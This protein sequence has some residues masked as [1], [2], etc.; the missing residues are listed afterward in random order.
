MVVHDPAVEAGN[1]RSTLHLYGADIAR[2]AGAGE[3]AHLVAGLKTAL[4]RDGLLGGGLIDAVVRHSAGHSV[5]HI[6]GQL[7]RRGGNFTVFFFH[8]KHPPVSSGR[9]PGRGP[10]A[11]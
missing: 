3:N 5:Q 4:L 9:G 8:W 1:S 7:Q 11:M 6:I 2:Q 10:S